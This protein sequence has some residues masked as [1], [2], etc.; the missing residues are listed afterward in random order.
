MEKDTT[1]PVE[2]ILGRDE[3]DREVVETL[4]RRAQTALKDRRAIEETARELAEAADRKS[5]LRRGVALAV[6]GQYEAAAEA[7]E[8]AGSSPVVDILLARCYRALGRCDEAL[9][10]LR[11]LNPDGW[12]RLEID[13]EIAATATAA[14]RP[15]EAVDILEKH[16]REGRQEPEYYFQLGRARE[17]AGD[18]QGAA[19]AYQTAL[20]R[21]EHPGAAF[22][23]GRLADLHGDDETAR[24]CYERCLS[25]AALYVNALISLGLLHE[26]AGEYEKAIECYSRALR[27]DPTNERAR[28]FLKDAEASTRM[29]IDE[30]LLRRVDRRNQVLETPV[31]D[32]EL[33]VRSRNCLQKM[34]VKTLGDLARCTEAELL[35]YK[36]FGETSLKEI[37]NL[38]AS[39]GLRLGMGREVEAGGRRKREPL[40]PDPEVLARSTDT[41]QLSVRG[42]NCL[43][44]LQIRTIGELIQCTEAELLACKNFGQTSLTELKN[45]LADLGLSLKEP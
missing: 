8:G 31:T 42:R 19:E 25:G 11:R 34:G 44:R 17:A 7:L 32:F 23:L 16:S 5:R 20:E 15:D 36:N 27:L 24:K 40:A 1:V 12:T 14:G 2:E 33:S 28:M 21:G 39:K 41:L 30:E 37:K 43:K 29:Y 26:D 22:H 4:S 38:L 10:V 9:Q 18:H 45:K 6:L 13:L 35:S 3:I